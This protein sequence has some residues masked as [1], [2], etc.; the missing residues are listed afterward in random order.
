MP[1]PHSACIDDVD[2]K[3][4]ATWLSRNAMSFSQILRAVPSPCWRECWATYCSSHHAWQQNG[5]CL[6]DGRVSCVKATWGPCS[7]L[8]AM[9]ATI[10]LMCPWGFPN[11]SL[12]LLC[13]CILCIRLIVATIVNLGPWPELSEPS[14][15]HE[16]GGM[17]TVGHVVADCR[18]RA[19]TANLERL[20]PMG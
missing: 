20:R 12:A 7:T 9:W 6:L 11:R 14:S 5:V 18:S 1:G 10:F 2:E 19:P 15:E 3:A 4:A 17:S 13:D 8:R 16:P